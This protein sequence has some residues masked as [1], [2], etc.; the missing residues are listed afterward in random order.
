MKLHV[1]HNEKKKM[2]CLFNTLVVKNEALERS[3]KGGLI[4]FLD[5]HGDQSNGKISVLCYMGFEFDTTIDD[6]V[7]NGLEFLEDFYFIDAG[8]YEQDVVVNDIKQRVNWLKSRYVNGYIYVWYI[9][10][11]QEDA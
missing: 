11:N 3:Y 7:K 9:D 2:Q 4:G 6:L 10:N 8:A 1:I 5:K